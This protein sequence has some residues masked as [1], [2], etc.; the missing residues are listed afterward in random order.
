MANATPKHMEPKCVTLLE[1]LK[2][3]QRV[4]VNTLMTA[5]II[6]VGPTPAPSGPNVVGKFDMC[7]RFNL[8][9]GR[10]ITS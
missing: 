6:L 10:L 9:D 3:V 2:I 4:V 1:V 5:S 7:F 8:L